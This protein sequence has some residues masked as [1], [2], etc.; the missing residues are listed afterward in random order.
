MSVENKQFVCEVILPENS[1]LHSATGRPASRKSTAKRSAAFE[2]CLILL[3]KGHLDKNLLSTYH[4]QLP[5]MRNAR[6]ALN[7]KTSNEYNMRIKPKLWSET[8]GSRPDRLYMT[9]L[10]LETPENLGRPS[11]PLSLLTRTLLPDF[12]SFQLYLQRNKT[13]NVLCKSISG[14][15]EANV[16]MMDELTEFTHRIYNDI[17]N[18]IYEVDQAMMSYWLAPVLPGW[19]QSATEQNPEMLI[20]WTIVKFVHQNQQAFT[21]TRDVPHDQLLD[22][23]IIDR[24]AGSRRF[25][26]EAVEPTMR[27]RDPIP[28]GSIRN[29]KFTNDILDHSINLYGKSRKS[30]KFSEDQPVM[31]T[32]QVPTRRN[33]LDEMTEDNK[34]E[35]TTCYVCPEPLKFSAVSI[36][37]YVSASAY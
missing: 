20:D 18:K 37:L 4:K 26:S 17:F 3:R 33:F 31:R 28:D 24:W 5:H 34:K 29:K 36:V 21:W 32:Y 15:F 19:M 8:R 11:Q 14:S 23:Y 22:R 9:V 25:F 30:Q 13:S 7:T 6:L 1:P 35:Q 16:P 10:Q 27:P 12:P 2:A